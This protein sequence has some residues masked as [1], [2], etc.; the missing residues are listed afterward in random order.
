[1]KNKNGNAFYLRPDKREL[2]FQ[3]SPGDINMLSQ[4]LPNMCKV[5][6][7]KVKTSHRLRL[8]C[9]R[10]LFQHGVEEKLNRER[11]GHRLDALRRY[12]KSSVKQNQ[13]VSAILALVCSAVVTN[14]K[15]ESDSY[16]IDD[17]QRS[18]NLENFVFN[19]CNVSFIVKK[20]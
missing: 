17:V 4:I 19:N 12:E 15:D 14:E 1:M 16:E 13:C 11:T 7:V 8:T 10:A 5:A 20:N 6:G 3:K 18:I 2:G 9:A